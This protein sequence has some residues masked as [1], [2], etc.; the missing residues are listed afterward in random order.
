[1]DSLML[2]GSADPYAEVKLVSEP[3]LPRSYT[4]VQTPHPRPHT[5]NPT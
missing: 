2:G 3:G 1:M 5:L 4:T